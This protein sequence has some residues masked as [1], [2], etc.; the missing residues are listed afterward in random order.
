MFDFGIEGYRPVW[1]DRRRDVA[2][3]HGDR[4]RAL[5]G[6]TLTRVWMVWDLGE[7][8]WFCDCPVLFEFDGEQ[9]EVNHQKLGDLSLTWNTIDPGRPVRWPGFDLQWRADPLPGLQPL[10]G[11]PLQRADL[12][13]WA[14]NDVAHGNVEIGFAFEAG[15]VRVFNALD[16][17]GLSFEAPGPNHRF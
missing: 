9:I 3:A 4:L 7:D 17:N 10:L 1:Q 14:G 13:E 5:A 11:L 2:R 8:E 12:L 15:Y 16:E 6:R